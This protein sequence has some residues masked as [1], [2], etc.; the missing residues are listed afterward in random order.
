MQV[1]TFYQT[2]RGACRCPDPAVAVE[3]GPLTV[4]VLPGRDHAPGWA[5]RR[6]S[7]P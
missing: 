6:S 7:R 2:R 1:W 4:G 5:R 3:P